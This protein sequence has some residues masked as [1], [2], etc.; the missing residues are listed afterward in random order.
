MMGD[1]ET[2]VPMKYADDAEDLPNGIHVHRQVMFSCLCPES[3]REFPWISSIR[4]GPWHYSQRGETKDKAI[5]NLFEYMRR[6][7]LDFE[8]YLQRDIERLKTLN[9]FL[10]TENSG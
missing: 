3:D 8:N 2:V 7:K 10:E 6:M 5:S 9:E 1:L 4:I